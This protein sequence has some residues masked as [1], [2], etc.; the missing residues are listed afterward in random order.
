MNIDDVVFILLLFADNMAIIAKS[1]EEL[2]S[3]LDLL[4]Q[5]CNMWGLKVGT[6]KTQVM[7]FRKHGR[8][9]A[10]ERWTYNGVNI[11]AVD[12]FN[13]LGVIFQYTGNFSFN[14]EHLVG[15]A[16]KAKNVLLNKC[17]EFDIQARTL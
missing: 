10:T 14:Q 6:Q 13:Y 7:V 9:L 8:L 12:D 3:Q 15:E 17:N 11:E 2:Q 1:P 16:L 5:Y 4:S